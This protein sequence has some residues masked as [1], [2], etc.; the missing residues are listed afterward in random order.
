MMNLLPHAAEAFRSSAPDRAL[1][2]RALDFLGLTLSY[3][4]FS[5]YLPLLQSLIDTP[6]RSGVIRRDASSVASLA[7]CSLGIHGGLIVSASHIPPDD[8]GGMFY[9]ERAGEPVP[10]VDP[11]MPD[12][13]DEVTHI[14]PLPWADAARSGRVH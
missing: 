2:A 4:D 14:K 12:L 5:P 8:N 13:V 9:D 3:A 1:N 10:P 11:I 7:A 6:H